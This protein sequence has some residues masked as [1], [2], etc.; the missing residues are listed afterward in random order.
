M[1]WLQQ[2]AGKFGLKTFATVNNEPWHVQITELQNGFIGAGQSDSSPDSPADTAEAVGDGGGGG[3]GGL[4]LGVDS[5]TG[6]SINAL[7]HGGGKGWKGTAASTTAG[8]VG[9]GVGAYTGGVLT[10]EQVAKMAYEAGFRGQALVDVV[11]IAGRESHYDPTAHNPNRKTGDNSYGLMQIN[12]I[13][14]LGPA[15]LQQFGLTSNEQLLDPMTNMRA[16]FSMYQSSGGTLSA[17]GAYKG[18]SNTYNTDLKAAA[19]AV[20]AAGITMG[21]PVDNAGVRRSGTLDRRAV[22]SPSRSATSTSSRVA[23]LRSMLTHS[24]GPS[25]RSSKRL[26]VCSSR[27]Q[28]DNRCQH[29]SRITSPGPTAT[30]TLTRMPCPASR[31]EGCRVGT[32]SGAPSSTQ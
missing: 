3:G 17:W 2:N 6:F 31:G 22:V 26:P 30:P 8:Q 24:S 27:G 28:R 20:A 5:G 13:D 12:M 11:A 9:G 1:E 21:D 10:A 18:K 19:A 25:H 4:N 7:L 16:A 23:T 32:S 15:R 29:R 14:K